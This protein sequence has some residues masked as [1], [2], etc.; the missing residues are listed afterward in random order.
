MDHKEIMLRT[1]EK[2]NIKMSH[3]LQFYLYN[4][5]KMS[6]L[7]REKIDYCLTGVGGGVWERGGCEFIGVARGR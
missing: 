5:L 2:Y 3:I 6:K 7:L 4:I 1:K